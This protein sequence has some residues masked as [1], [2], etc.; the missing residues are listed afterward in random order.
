MN[1]GTTTEQASAQAGIMFHEKIAKSIYDFAVDSAVKD[2]TECG[3]FWFYRQATNKQMPYISGKS[4]SFIGK[5]GNLIH[6]GP[7]SDSGVAFYFLLNWQP[8]K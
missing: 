7:Y 1:N 8:N 5:D 3:G 4:G 2:K 6:F